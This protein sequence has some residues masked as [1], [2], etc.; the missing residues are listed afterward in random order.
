MDDFFSKTNA[1]FMDYIS[2]WGV[3]HTFMNQTILLS[4]HD[5]DSGIKTDSPNGTYYSD[6]IHQL[7]TSLK[8]IDKRKYDKVIEKIDFL[9][10]SK[11]RDPSI[12]PFTKFSYIFWSVDKISKQPAYRDYIINNILNIIE[13]LKHD[14]T[15]RLEDIFSR[16]RF[17]EVD[18][19]YPVFEDLV[20]LW[21]PF[22]IFYFDK[23]SSHDQ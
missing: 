1:S 11:Y 18:I 6:I 5:S 16:L 2:P 23:P 4:V 12:P 19:K 15:I 9:L 13:L 17:G 3:L 20:M 22:F 21:I 10:V 8:N 14:R 7:K